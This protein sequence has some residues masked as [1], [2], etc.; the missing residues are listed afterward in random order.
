[1][2]HA[3]LAFSTNGETFMTDSQGNL[4]KLTEMVYEIRSRALNCIPLD[5]TLHSYRF[6]IRRLCQ[7]FN[8]LVTWKYKHHWI[9]FLDSWL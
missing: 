6:K 4:K 5:S 1:M 2:N 7:I 9:I 8:C 3:M